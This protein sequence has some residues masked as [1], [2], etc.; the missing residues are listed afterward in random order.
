MRETPPAAARDLM[1]DAG[2]GLSLHVI[3]SGRGSP[4]MLLHGFTGSTHSWDA[5]GPALSA[6]H[7]IILV[8]L[9]GHGQ[10]TAPPDL[11]RYALP[12]TADDVARVLDVL[13]VERSAVLGYSLGGRAALHLAVQHPARVSAL[14]LEGSS[15]GIADEAERERRSVSD[16]ALADRI[17]RD[18]VASFV[19]QWEALPLWHSQGVLPAPTRD[20]L[21]AQRL[22]NRAD[23]L[24]RSLRGAGVG[25]QAPLHGRLSHLS[26]PVMLVAG[27]LDDRY[28]EQGRLMQRA[29]PGARLVEVQDAGHAVHLERPAELATVVIDFLDGR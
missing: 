13:G 8:D 29:I 2:D 26:M 28:V 4:L 23:G 14:V 11:P 5:L 19:D 21:R 6:R 27:A 1:V 20:R 25:T 17:E 9:P 10:S 16:A 15:A 24:A 3:V 22:A 12:R 18:G 7:M